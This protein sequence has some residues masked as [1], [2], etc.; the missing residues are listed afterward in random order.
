MVDSIVCMV[1]R[2][3]KERKCSELLNGDRCR[4]VVVVL[5]GGRWSL[6]AVDFIERLAM[7]RRTTQSATVSFSVLEAPLD[8]HD[9][10]FMRTVVCQLV[11]QSSHPHALAGVDGG[12][13]HLAEVLLE[14]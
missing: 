10:H 4:L 13:P 14:E 5:E 11:A 9:R 8:S 3:D 1:A 6:E 12:V 7:A 2:A